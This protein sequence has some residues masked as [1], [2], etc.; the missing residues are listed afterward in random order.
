[1]SPILMQSRI[2]NYFSL[3]SKLLLRPSV[4]IFF[5]PFSAYKSCYF[6]LE[7]KPDRKVN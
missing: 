3:S 5:P 4:L 1:M 2:E 7:K 6:E